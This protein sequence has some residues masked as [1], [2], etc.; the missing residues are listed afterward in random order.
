MGG[1]LCLFAKINNFG[2]YLP[3]PFPFLNFIPTGII[4]TAL[5]NM[6]RENREQYQVVIQ[7]KD[8][9]GQGWEDYLGLP[10]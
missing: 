2:K 1:N 9:G 6:D 4:K 7:A 3:H 10:R 8:M 5:L